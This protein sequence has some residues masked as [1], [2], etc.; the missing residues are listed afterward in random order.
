MCNV[1]FI[2]ILEHLSFI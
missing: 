2:A 1:L